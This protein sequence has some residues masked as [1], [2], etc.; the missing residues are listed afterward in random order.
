VGLL[1]LHD[2]IEMGIEGRDL[3]DLDEGEPH[4][5]RERR[6]MA[7]VQAAEMVL[8]EVEV[9]DQQVGAARTITEQSFDSASAWVRSAGLWARCESC[10]GPSLDGS[11]APRLS[12][13]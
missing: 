7:R 4:G 13:P 11:T 8:Q 9:L 5:I 3:V 6:E 10:G 1:P 2:D 12:R